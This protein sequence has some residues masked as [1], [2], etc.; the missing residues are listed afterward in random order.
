[1][2]KAECLDTGKTFGEAKLH[3]TFILD[4]YRYFAAA[5]ETKEEVATE[6][7]FLMGA[8][9]WASLPVRSVWR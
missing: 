5:I 4:T 3:Q 9:I 6:E 7:D 2:A 1:M 8:N